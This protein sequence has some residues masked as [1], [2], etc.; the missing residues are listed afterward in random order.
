MTTV[1]RIPK[2]GR[3]MCRCHQKATHAV[4]R[5]GRVV[6]VGCCFCAAKVAKQTEEAA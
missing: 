1:T 3:A 2:P 6:F 4:S 5:D